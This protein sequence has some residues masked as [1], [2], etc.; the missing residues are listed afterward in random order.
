MFRTALASGLPITERRNHSYRVQYYEPAGTDATIY[1]PW[2]D[3]KFIN[4]TDNYILIQSRIEGDNLYFDFW[5][6]K[7]GREATTTYPKIY[8]IKKPPPT[9][10]IETLDLKPG[11]KKCT[12]T[13]HNGADAYFFYTVK[14]PGG[15]I[16]EEKFISHYV[17]WQEV[18]LLG[19]E[20]LSDHQIASSSAA[21]G[22]GSASTTGQN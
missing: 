15:E 13:S 22:S 20:K 17:P 8:N 6:K 16:K 18:C 7:D 21:A 3:L 19:V 10:I 14:Y 1:D 12:E 11:V 4:D 9:K 5:G 2:P